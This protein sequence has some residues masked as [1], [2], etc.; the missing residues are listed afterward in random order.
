[1]S[2]APALRRPLPDPP[3]QA[4]E[5]NPGPCPASPPLPR[6][7]RRRARL[8]FSSRRRHTRFDCD[9]SSDVCSSDLF[10][11]ALNDRETTFANGEKKWSKTVVERRAIFGAGVQQEI[12]DF[13]VSV[14]GRPHDRGLDRK[15]TRL[16]SSHSQIS[17]AVFCLK[18]KKEQTL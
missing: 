17:Y 18:K 7:T 2:R 12:D 11:E 13:D 14:G 16:N 1:M 8:F 9:W 6:E 3:T 4:R 10:D 5:G 15:S